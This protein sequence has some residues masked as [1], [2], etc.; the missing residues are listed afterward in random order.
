MS[1]KPQYHGDDLVRI[2]VVRLNDAVEG[3]ADLF[4]D[5][6]REDAEGWG[7]RFNDLKNNRQLDAAEQ[8]VAAG[9]AHWESKINPSNGEN[10]QLLVLTKN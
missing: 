5:L 3:V 2:E 9:F 10:F 6:K 7:V 8:L 1:E 4:E